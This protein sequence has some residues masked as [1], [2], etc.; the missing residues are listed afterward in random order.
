MWVDSDGD[1]IQDPSEVGVPGVTVTLYDSNTGAVI[2]TVMTDA[3]GEYLFEDI[4]EG[5]YYINFDPSTNTAGIDYP[6]T[7]TN[8]GNGSNDSDADASGSTA[9]FSFDPN[10]GDDL[11]WDA[12]LVPVAD[13][14]DYVFIDNNGDGLQDATD[15]PVE[16]VTV[17]L[18]DSNTGLP[19]ATVTTDANGEYLFEDVPSGDYYIDF[20]ASTSTTPGASDYGWAE[21]GQGDGTNDSEVDPSG[22][23]PS[24]SF[25][26]ESGDDLTHDAGLTPVADIGNFVWIDTDGDGLQDP[27]EMGIENVTVILYDAGGNPVDTAYTDANGEYVFEDVPAG[28]YYLIFDAS[29]APGAPEYLFTD[30]A[31][32]DG[33]NDSEADATG[34]TPLFTFDPA[35]GDDDTHDAGLVPVADIGNFVWVDADGDGI[36]YPNE[37]GLEN[38]EV[39]LYD[40]TTGLP[41]D[42]VFTDA[43]G[44][45]LFED[46][47]AGDYFVGFDPSTSPT[48]GANF[49]FTDTNSGNGSNDSDADASGFTSTFDFDPMNGSDL[50]I[51]AGVVP[52]AN[53]GDL[54]WVDSDGDGIQDP[55]ENGVEGVTVILYDAD[56]GLPVDTVMTDINGNYLF[57]DVPTGNYF[58]EFDATTGPYGDEF[59]YTQFQTG[60]DGENSDADANGNSPVFAFDAFAGD[61]MTCDAGI[62]PTPEIRTIKNVLNTNTLASGNVEITFELGVKNTGPVDLTNISLVDDLMTQL[63]AAYN[64]ITFPPTVTLVASTATSTPALDGTFDGMGNNDIFAGAATDLLEPG[65]EVKVNVT[66]TIDPDLAV[67][68][69]TNQANAAGDGLDDDGNP[70]EDGSGNPL[71]V[72]D[73]SDAGTDYEG[74][75][76]GVPGDQGTEDDPTILDCIPA[77]I[78]ITGE[79]NGICPG[80]NISL[81]VTS[82]IP[83]ATYEWREVG[84][85]VIISTDVNPT[86]FNLQDTTHYEVTVINGTGTCYYALQDTTVINVFEAPTV[87]PDATYNLNTDCSPSDLAL[88]ADV[89]AGSGSTLTFIWSGPNGFTS[90]LENPTIVNAAEINNGTYNVTVTDENGCMGTGNVEV[91]GIVDDVA[92]PLIT[93]TGPACEGETVVLSI[94]AYAGSTVTYTWTTADGTFTNITGESTNAITIS[95]VIDAVHQG[96]YTVTINVDGCELTSPILDLDVFDTP[97]ANPSYT[98]PDSCD[99]G[100]LELF[101]NA[102]GVGLLTYL[103]EGPNGWTSTLENPVINNIDVNYNGQYVLTV[104]TVSGCNAQGIIPVD[105]I[106]PQAEAPAIASPDVEICDGEDIVLTTS[107]G[108]TNFEWIGPLGASQSTLMLAGLT[109]STGS[110][111]IPPGHPSYVSGSYSV[112]VT[113]ADGCVVESESINITIHPIPSVTATNNSPVCEGGDITLMASDVIGATYSW[114][115]T[116]PA[117]G[118]A[119]LVSLD[120]NPIIS[121]LMTG[122]YTYYLTVEVNG[123]ISPTASTIVTINAAP[124]S[125]PTATYTLNTDCS[126]SD[127]SLF[128]NVSL[129][130]APYTFSWTG[131]NGWSSTLEN[132][133]IANVTAAN[134][135]TYDVIVTDINGCTAIGNVEVNGIVDQIAQPLI[136]SSGP[137]CEGETIVLTIPAYAGSN[138]TY[139]WTTADG[140]FTNITGENTNEIT[141]SP[142]VDANHDGDYTVTINVDGC[143]LTSQVYNLE[144]F[145]T[146]SALPT[147]TTPDNCTDGSLELF[148]NGT[149]ITDLTYNWTGPNGFI[150][151]LEN[152]VV[153]NITTANNGEYVVTVTT[154]S[155]CTFTTSVLVNTILPPA[156]IPTIAS[157]DVEICDGEDIVLLT[158]ASGTLFEWIGPL[159]ASTGTLALAGLTTPTGSTVIP[160]GHPSYLSGEYSVRVTDANGCTATSETI[161]ITIHPIPAV[162]ATN[163]SPV[164]EGTD[165]TLHANGVTGATYRW[166]DGD[167]ALAASTLISQDQDP[168]MQG[169]AAGLHDFYVTVEVNGCISPVS[170]TTVTINTNPVAVPSADYNPVSNCAPTDLFLYA[171]AAGGSGSYLFSWTGPNGF[172]SNVENPIIPN[173][174]SDNNG[175][176]T[177]TL[178]DDFGCTT[179]GTVE[180]TNIVDPLPMPLV[181][182]SGQVC[183]GELVTIWVPEYQGSS[184]DYVWTMP[185]TVN[186]TGTN[187]HELTIS[188]VDSLLHEGNY[189]VVITIDG[190][191]IMSDTFNLELHPTPSAMPTVPTTPLC[192]GDVLSFMA[193]ATGANTYFWTG[194]NGFTSN[195]QDLVIPNITIANNGTYTLTVTNITGCQSTSS[196][197]VSNIVPTP[198]TP[199]ITTNSPVCID[200]TIELAIQEMYTG[201]TVTYNWTN[202]AGQTIGTGIST[203]SISSNDPLAISPY[204]VSVTVDGC[205]SDLSTPTPV[206]VNDL[207]LAIA[208][209]GGAICPDSDG[210]LFA[211]P[212]AGASYE[213]RELGSTTIIST[214]QNPVIIGLTAT[215]TYE[216]TVILNGCVSNP[217]ATTTIQVTPN[218][219]VTPTYNYSLNADCSPS[220]LSLFANASFGVGPYNFAWTGPNGFNSSLE[221]PIIANVTEM[222]NGTYDLTITDAN[223]CV[224]TGNL[225]VNGITDAIPQPVISTDGIIC[226]GGVIQISIPEYIGSSVIYDWTIPSITNV[227]GLNTNVL[228]I[229]PVDSAMHEGNYIVQVTIDGCVITSNIFNLELHPTPT[230]VP[231]STPTPMCEG[232]ELSL[233][234]N[235]I[236]ASTYVW[237][238]PNGF[239]SNAENPVLSN[240]TIANNGTYTLTVT[241]VTGCSTTTEIVVSNISETPATPVITAVNSVCTDATFTLAVQQQYVGTTVAYNWTNGV[242]ATIG[243]GA[244]VTMSPGSVLAISPYR[245][246]VTVNDCPS[247]LSDPIEIIEENLPPAVATNGGAICPDEVAQL[248]ANPIAGASY[249]WRVAG[250]PLIVSTEQNPLIPLSASTV[251]ELTVISVNGCVSNPLSYTQQIV[252]GAPTANPNA[253]YSV[254]ADCTPADLTLTS[255]ATGTGLLYTWTGPNGYTS[256]AENPVISNASSDNNGSYSLVVTTANGCSTTGVTNVVIDITNQVAQ[257]IIASTGPA[258]EGETIVLTVTQYTGSNVNYT[259]TTPSGTFTNITGENTNEIVISPINTTDH[260]GAY[261]LT[262]SVD[263]CTLTSDTYS[264]D[265]FDIPTATPSATATSICDGGMLEL[266]AAGTGVGNLTYSWVGPNGFTSNLEN[267]NINTTSP[268]NNGQYTVTV[269]SVSGCSAVESIMVNNILEAP[270]APTIFTDQMICEGDDIV[271]TTSAVGTTFEW[272]GPLGASQSTLALPGLTTNTGTTTLPMGNQAYMM[273]EWQVQVTD[274]NGCT[275]LSD[276]ISLTINEIPVAFASNNGPVCKQEPVQLFAGQIQNGEYRWYDGDPAASPAPNLISTDQ[277]PI[278]Y[279]VPAGV[280]EYF[281]EVIK[282]E[283]ESEVAAKTTVTINEQPVIDAIVGNGSYCEGTDILL[284]AVNGAPLAGNITYTWTGPNGFSFTSNTAS[285][286]SFAVNLPNVS[287]IMEGTYTL[288]LISDSGCESEVQSVNIDLD[289]TPATPL[290]QAN[291]DSLCEGENLE[292]NT[293]LFTGTP[294]SY[295]WFF[296]DGSGMVSLGTTTSP[297]FFINGVTPNNAGIYSVQT[298]VDGCI[299]SPSNIMDVQVFGAFTTPSAGNTTSISSP[300]CEGDLVQLN[301]PF[302]TGADYQWY[303]PNGFSSSLPNP[304]INPVSIDDIGSYYAVITLDNNC[305]VMVSDTTNVY[306]QPQPES[307]TITSSGPVCEGSDFVLS[308]SSPIN[309]PSGTVFNYDWYY[310]PTNALVGTTTTSSFT[311]PNALQTNTGDYYVI[312]TVGDCAAEP[313]EVTPVQVDF[314]PP[315]EADAGEDIEICATNIYSLDGETPTIGTGF[316][317]SPSGATISNPEL[318]DTEVIDL[319]Q[320]ENMFIWTLSNGACENYDADTVIVTVTL[321]PSDIAYAGEDFNICGDSGSS[322]NANVPTSATGMWT[323]TLFQASLGVV[324]VD[325]TSPNTDVTGMISGNTYLFT[326]SLSQGVCEEF[327]TDEVIVTVN[328]APTVNAFVPEHEIYSCGEEFLTINANQPSIGTGVWTTSSSATIVEPSFNSTIID[329]LEPGTNMFIWTLSNGACENYSS[330]TLYVISEGTDIQAD[331]DAYEIL[332]DETIDNEDIMVNDFTGNINE[333]DITIIDD[334]DNGTI[335]FFEDGVFSYEPNDA[336]FGMDEFIYQICNVNCPSVCDT[337]IVTIRVTGLETTGDCW[338]PNVMTPNDDGLN[339]NFVIPCLDI[340]PNARLCIF[341]RWGDRILEEKPY[342][343]DW[344][345]TYKGKD[346]PPGTYFYVLQPDPD[347]ND[348]IEGYFTIIR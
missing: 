5:D 41:I 183:D 202:G 43:N 198:I 143:E 16:G 330:D 219:A 136:T 298:T 187:T 129:G 252:H 140:T 127:L 281:L 124:I 79:P 97:T 51:D 190:C 328:E 212:I 236:G 7:D 10:N 191:V 203:V 242:G 165:V 223:G 81:S 101:A 197:D 295:E 63:G 277:N 1:G 249:E 160:P 316:W 62:I 36:Q 341:N 29:T 294:V 327:A 210:Q 289:A 105:N 227:T 86:F 188:P 280:H 213:W 339:D 283:C 91:N 96:N 2:A 192:E 59:T 120:Q 40:A 193:N 82:D 73:D 68:P 139:A 326:W 170:I 70:L 56:T 102:S 218:P 152:P 28:D 238:G 215:T 184:V 296:D 26:A 315:N 149:G 88:E 142:V 144:V 103:W 177:V 226:D 42:T 340:Y 166:Y 150:S 321:I 267:P 291:D 8:T 164:C 72:T 75:N 55:G 247:N 221:N 303:G 80:E 3:N 274:A 161:T 89:T 323:Q 195:A 269:T 186:V 31:Q 185:S 4:P 24:F 13:I 71:T 288:T 118:A 264:V 248:F 209:N 49:L 266:F 260:Q 12:G 69:M 181:S 334:V 58:I 174:T 301:L 305:T 35:N 338:V 138:V 94:P 39:V 78:V 106:L 74:T 320:G 34:Q 117:V 37:I 125:A 169:L 284:S 11:T 135:G 299:S 23:T 237:N 222:F 317:T 250:N 108:G 147:F 132:P 172:T 189:S 347:S 263:G 312:M 333:W 206:I 22:S 113:N 21:A 243:T 199:T 178:T 157:T 244:T 220:D 173:A 286:A 276:P 306:I 182:T 245:V 98:T 290:L 9:S 297:T 50:T 128:A 47:P 83:G 162:L 258:C 273:G 116:D 85:T 141:I 84:S 119:N 54:V 112:R 216:L 20:D 163:D 18:Y 287:Q 346:L 322:L 100:V 285:N 15:T 331:A 126:P 335:T 48:S 336:F 308:V 262:V 304:V 329:D 239:T 256:N 99:G 337:A 282:F 19:V 309:Y 342:K 61:K 307:P 325:P 64:G 66:I 228:T 204:R 345:G 53:I 32:G 46:L 109:T 200:G 279:N 251:F 217:L 87:S 155:G 92:Q 115:D 257:P 196:V 231:T 233:T 324:I 179:I 180:V 332:F 314:V 208:T 60:L 44:E 134:N 93:S 17:T 176:Y 272:V 145:D 167:P 6:F 156:E 318:H 159:G 300:A 230:A 122:V 137:A 229:N 311:Y 95:P 151:T 255:N 38:V 265:V 319:I 76:P 214:E 254:N 168:V 158:S 146:P 27:S 211:N 65:Q 52:S 171:N 344:I 253:S 207:P 153:N 130:T 67:Y 313:S 310:A 114:W 30:S 292:L 194:P 246:T 133:T 270:D 261:T 343:N 293:D 241:N 235:A 104:T 77:N 201:T 224:G 131:P 90:T 278:L 33:T 14:G 148:A 271:L 302:F 57:T 268:A 240:I 123:C 154:V 232:A 25:D 45:Y 175:S 121:N 110:T 348:K 111:S 259:W 275:V 225:L 205:T 234:A 107:A